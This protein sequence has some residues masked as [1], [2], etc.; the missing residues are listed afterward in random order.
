MHVNQDIYISKIMEVIAPVVRASLA[1]PD[2]KLNLNKRKPED[3][4]NPSL[5]LARQFKLAQDVLNVTIPVRLFIQKELAGA[6]RDEARSNPPAIITGYTLLS[7]YRPVDLAFVCGRH[8]TYYRGEHFIRTMYQSH[9]EL[10][11][12]LLAAMRVVG[13]GGGDATVESTAKQLAKHMDQPHLDV[14]KQ[15]VRKFVDAGGHA[16]IKRWMQAAEIT[17]LRAG[18]LLCDDVDTAVHMTQQ[19]AS[20]STADLAPRDK[21]KEIVLFS[22]SESYFR[23][24]EQLG[25]QIKV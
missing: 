3:L 20:E 24:R 22:I 4:A 19:I 6:L 5:A 16:D 23:L 17:A 15:V 12:L 1:V 8:L 13:M 18:L 11:T 2:K 14:L 10:K 21:V 25:I 9:T 7:G